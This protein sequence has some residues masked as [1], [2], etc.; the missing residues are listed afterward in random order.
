MRTT[1]LWF[2]E[3][4]R[5]HRGKRSENAFRRPGSSPFPRGSGPLSLVL[6]RW[7]SSR[8]RPPM[9]MQTASISD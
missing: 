6:T 9:I 7:Q 2:A 4:Y 3:I 1:A 5:R 8:L